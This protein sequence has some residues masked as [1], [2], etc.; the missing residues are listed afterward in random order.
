MNWLKRLIGMQEKTTT[1]LE[2]IE[3]ATARIADVMEATADEVER[4]FGPIVQAPTIGA[5]STPPAIPGKPERNGRHRKA[6]ALA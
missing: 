5:P 6:P 3:K 1:D 4:R 2:R